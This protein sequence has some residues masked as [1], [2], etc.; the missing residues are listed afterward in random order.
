MQDILAVLQMIIVPGRILI[1]SFFFLG[2]FRSTLV[3]PSRAFWLSI[4][5]RG[6][7]SL[8]WP[9]R[10]PKSG[11]HVFLGFLKLAGF[12]GV[13][14]PFPPLF[15]FFAHPRVYCW[16]HLRWMCPPF[17]SSRSLLYRTLII[18]TRCLF[19]INFNSSTIFAR[20]K[21]KSDSFLRNSVQQP[22]FQEWPPFLLP[23]NLEFL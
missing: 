12:L 9:I 13:P 21:V 15:Y 16:Y 14:L 22:F 4:D 20:S 23:H 11:Q 2:F 19:W 1:S 5:L 18:L 17:A 8:K 3:Q 10:L 7:A 6:S